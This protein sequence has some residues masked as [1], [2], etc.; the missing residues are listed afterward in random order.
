MNPEGRNF[1][2]P[3]NEKEFNELKNGKDIIKHYHE[4]LEPL[5]LFVVVLSK[6]KYDK[7]DLKV[8]LKSGDDA[9]SIQLNA[10]QISILEEDSQ[11]V[12]KVSYKKFNIFIYSEQSEY[13][14]G[15]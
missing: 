2:L 5:P 10:E 13:Y 14:Q 15:F 4:E 8:F 9:T 3:L 12:L 1:Q 11:H 7:K 6:K